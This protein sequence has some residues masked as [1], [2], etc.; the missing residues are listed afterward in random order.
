MI[1]KEFT[2]PAFNG[3]LAIVSVALGPGVYID[4]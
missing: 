1:K 4:Q 3:N 2:Y